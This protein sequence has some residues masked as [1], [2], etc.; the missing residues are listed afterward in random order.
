M[1]KRKEKTELLE[2]T[3]AQVHV[4][5]GLIERYQRALSSDSQPP[6]QDIDEQQVQR[7]LE[8]VGLRERTKPVTEDDDL[9]EGREVSWKEVFMGR[10]RSHLTEKEQEDAARKEWEQGELKDGPDIY[11]KC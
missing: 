4:L 6:G 11:T 7:E 5:N 3:E 8:M 9:W 2:K 10:K 1:V